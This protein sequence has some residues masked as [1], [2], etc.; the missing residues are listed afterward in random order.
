M[1]ISKNNKI[2]L[3]KKDGVEILEDDIKFL[4]TK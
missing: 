4:N 3:F 2:R 1:K